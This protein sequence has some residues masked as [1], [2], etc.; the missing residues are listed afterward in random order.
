M[1]TPRKHFV[2]LSSLIVVFSMAAAGN[3]KDLKV[4]LAYLPGVSESTD[5][6]PLVDMVKTLD[7]EYPGGKITFIGVFPMEQSIKAVVDGAADFHIPLLG[8]P[9]IPVNKLPYDYVS[10]PMG[11]VSFVI[12]SHK[13][14]PITRKMIDSAKK[15]PSKFPYKIEIGQGLKEYF[16]FPIIESPSIELSMKKVAERKA[17]CFIWAQEESDHVVRKLQLSKIHRELYQPFDDVIIIKKGEKG[18][19]TDNILSGVIKRM[20]A[21]GRWHEIYKKFHVPYDPWQPEKMGW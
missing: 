18:I 6:G 15:D 5:K 1:N 11:K 4:S 3:T 16:D 7:N 9:I 21:D 2:A 13:D 17:D 20:K 19:E 12:Y 8:N 10:E 14:N